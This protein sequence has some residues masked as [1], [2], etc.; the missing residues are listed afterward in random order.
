M[1]FDPPSPN[2]WVMA[3]PYDPHYAEVYAQGYTA[4]HTGKDEQDNPY[5]LSGH[6]RDTTHEDELHQWW[7]SGWN[8]R[9]KERVCQSVQEGL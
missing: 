2:N 8:D 7:W 1:A 4:A 5:A 3:W 9:D 6:E